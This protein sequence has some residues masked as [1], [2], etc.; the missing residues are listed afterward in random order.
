M[1]LCIIIT[2]L[3]FYVITTSVIKRHQINKQDDKFNIQ[4]RKKL[5]IGDSCYVDYHTY[6]IIEIKNNKVLNKDYIK[7]LNH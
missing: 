5:V 7:N 4:F 2:I 1:Y 3:V 6:K